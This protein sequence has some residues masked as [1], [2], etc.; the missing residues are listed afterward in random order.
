MKILNDYIKRGLIAFVLTFCAALMSQAITVTENAR[1][2]IL[3]C[4]PGPD[5]YSV[6]GHTAIRFE[7]LQEGRIVDIVYN[8]GTFDF[9]T[10]NF[11]A[12]FATGK[13]PYMLS[14]ASF[15]MFQSEYL[16]FGRGIEEQE[17]ILSQREK[18]TLFDLLEENFKPEN[19]TYRY[20][21][22]YDNCSTRVRDIIVKALD[23]QA[24]FSYVYPAQITFRQ[25]I[26]TYLN[27]QPWS[28]FGIDI[29]LGLP[30][31]R[32]MEA[33]QG[34][35]LPDSLLKEFNYGFAGDQPIVHQAAELLPKEFELSLDTVF[36]PLFVL[37]LFLALH[38]IV[39]LLVLKRRRKTFQLT[40]RIVFFTV[41]LIG[42]LVVFLW[43]FTDHQA[44]KWNLNILWANPLVLIFA[45]SAK[46]SFSGWKNSFLNG[47]LILLILTVIFWF[48]IPQKLPIPA[49]PLVLALIFSLLKL[50]RPQVF[51]KKR[52]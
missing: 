14:K 1:F 45:F 46:S 47:Y 21:F 24:T 6:F 7:D 17:L 10:K 35:F 16:H 40:D 31:D 11:Y 34:M 27:Y 38:L 18:Q 48:V 9:Q 23:N 2:T 15:G 49:I 29:A 39:G 4:S 42:L 36:T 28:D 50:Q 30:C 5:L 41:G 33:G 13:L 43:F 8:Y 12:K 19:R 22:F 32:V 20:D 25:A 26:Q 51:V 3:T 37:G 52:S 44:T